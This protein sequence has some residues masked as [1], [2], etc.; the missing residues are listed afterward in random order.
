MA[1]DWVPFATAAVGSASTA[2]VAWFGF[3]HGERL[4]SQRADHERQLAVDARKQQR[5]AEAYVPLLT[6]AYRV[7]QWSDLVRPA[8]QTAQTP[9]PPPLPTLEEQA[10][11]QAL[12]GA[13]AS[14]TV[15]DFMQAW[16]EVLTKVRVA[17]MTIGFAQEK[18]SRGVIDAGEQWIRL[19]QDLRPAERHARQALVDQVSLELGH[20][21]ISTDTKPPDTDESNHHGRT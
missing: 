12:V 14:S 9:P 17:N 6:F 8:I 16:Q 3:R 20:R 7:G 1:W 13:Y 2:L 4:A 21:Q 5:L 11:I 15:R 19:E 18:E 10:K